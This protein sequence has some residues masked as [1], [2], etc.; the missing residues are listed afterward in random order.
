MAFSRDGRP[1]PAPEGWAAGLHSFGHRNIQGAVFDDKGAFWVVEHG[2]KGGDELNRVEA[3][4]NYGWPVISYGV[5]YSGAKIGVGT[6]A[7]GLEQPVHYWD[8]SIA[9]SGLMSY[10]GA[11]IP[12]WRGSLLT[13]SLKF[14]QIHRLDPSR[15]FAEEILKG[16]ATARLRDLREGPDGAIWF[17]SVG[18]G[19]LYRMAPPK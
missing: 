5:D 18:Q 6:E 12:G 14:G 17:L 13:G 2:A 7:P 11:L 1:K 19:A 3:G 10:Q 16:A 15:G 4:R 8:P 9:P